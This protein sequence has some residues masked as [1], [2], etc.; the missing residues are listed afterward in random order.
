MKSIKWLIVLGAA[1]VGGAQAASCKE[2]ENAQQKLHTAP[3]TLLRDA[4]LYVDNDVAY[5][6]EARIE[7]KNGKFTVKTLK[8]E[9]S[10]TAS[11]DYK[12]DDQLPEFSCH[13]F[14]PQGK[15]LLTREE[16][17]EMDGGAR[18]AEFV[19]REGKLFPVQVIESGSVGVL[20]FKKKI[21]FEVKY[22]QN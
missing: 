10:K 14:A 1:L 9:Q 2:L 3:F 5:H 11:V 22:R 16:I 15:R 19:L 4:T 6:E 7:F 20:F 12:G 13:T 18:E 17:K 8:K 21:R